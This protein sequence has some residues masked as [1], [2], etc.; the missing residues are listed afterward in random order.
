MAEHSGTTFDQPSRKRILVLKTQLI[1]LLISL[2]IIPY[3]F[4]LLINNKIERCQPI[5]NSGITINPVGEYI[6]LATGSLSY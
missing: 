2:M 5:L 3:R 1:E 4:I 6:A